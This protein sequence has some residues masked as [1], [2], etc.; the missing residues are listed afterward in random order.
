MGLSRLDWSRFKRVFALA[1]AS[2]L[3]ALNPLEI[4]GLL[5]VNQAFGRGTLEP[6]ALLRISQALEGGD[7]QRLQDAGQQGL[8]N[9]GAAGT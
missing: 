8:H 4:E 3:P 2:G 9:S 6:E 1:M 7:R 5:R